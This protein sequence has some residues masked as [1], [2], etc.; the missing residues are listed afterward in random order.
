MSRLVSHGREAAVFLTNELERKNPARLE[1]IEKALVMIGSDAVEPLL[2]KLSSPNHTVAATSARLLGKIGSKD[3]TLP[4]MM[5]MRSPCITLRANA[6]LA[7]GEIGDP[8]AVDNL[9]SALSDPVVEVRRNAAIA[10][11][12]IGDPAPLNALVD[13][14][15]D[16]DYS[17]RYSASN[18]IAGINDESI[19]PI[20]EDI[21]SN[22]TTTAKYHAI[23]I[24][25]KISDESSIQKLLSLTES[26]DHLARGFS[27]IALSNYRGRYEI[28]NAIKKGLHD[29]SPFVRTMSLKAI[30]LLKVPPWQRNIY[31]W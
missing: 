30:K 31:D 17:V 1:I 12:K 11:G 16:N 29:N 25:G 26:P 15:H 18:A 21:I 10:L 14:L 6:C 19:L 9:A 3:A 28:A 5:A 8:A 13:L 24:L 4:L 7:L 23:D 20:L 27:Y 22:D 2:K